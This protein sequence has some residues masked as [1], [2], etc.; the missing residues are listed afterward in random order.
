MAV[1]WVVIVLLLPAIVSSLARLLAGSRGAAAN[2]TDRRAHAFTPD[3]EILRPNGV[4][5]SFSIF[6]V[7]VCWALLATRPVDRGERA[8]RSQGAPNFQGPP[9]ARSPVGLEPAQPSVRPANCGR[10]RRRT[11][12]R[13]RDSDSGLGS[14]IDR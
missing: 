8:G 3:A 2:V 5:L 10:T 9:P 1:S 12:A 13:V 6:H 11:P 14:L 4:Y 7:C